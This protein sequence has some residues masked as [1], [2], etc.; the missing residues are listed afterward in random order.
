MSSQLPFP[1]RVFVR[2][3]AVGSGL[4]LRQLLGRSVRGDGAAGERAVLDR[5]NQA[6][7]EMQDHRQCLYNI[8]EIM[9]EKCLLSNEQSV[10]ALPQLGNDGRTRPIPR[11]GH[12]ETFEPVDNKCLLRATDGKKK[13]STVV[14]SR[15]VNKFQMA[16]SNLIRANMDGLKK[17]DKKSKNKKSKATQ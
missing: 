9:E 4:F 12:L 17:K 3:A 5:A 14:S 13:I 11:K 16:Y 8:K 1:D 2:S 7:S 15:E 6:F 10:M